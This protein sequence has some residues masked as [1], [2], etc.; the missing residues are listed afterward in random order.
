MSSAVHAVTLFWDSEDSC[1]PPC[2]QLLKGFDALKLLA[3]SQSS[4]KHSSEHAGRQACSL[5]SQ[6][7]ICVFK[8][9][10]WCA[11]DMFLGCMSYCSSEDGV[12][13]HEANNSLCEE[14]PDEEALLWLAHCMKVLQPGVLPFVLRSGSLQGMHL[15]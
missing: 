2:H 6:G 1:Q 7:Q 15:L 8:S 14:C 3:L 13:W 12:R 9:K 10:V 4:L 5:H 11:P